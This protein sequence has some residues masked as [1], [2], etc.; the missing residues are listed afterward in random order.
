MHAFARTTTPARVSWS[1]AQAAVAHLTLPQVRRVLRL[2][3]RVGEDE[4]IAAL[5]WH[6]RCPMVRAG[7]ADPEVR[8]LVLEALGFRVSPK[9][10]SHGANT[11]EPWVSERLTLVRW[12]G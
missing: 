2:A 4:A 7:L 5:V 12:V 8:E 9:S 11:T 1:Q 10:D 3:V 6:V